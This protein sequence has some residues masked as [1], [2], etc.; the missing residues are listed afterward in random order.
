MWNVRLRN[1]LLIFAAIFMFA[2]SIA[3]ISPPA[4]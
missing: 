4:P 2:L 3:L 1:L